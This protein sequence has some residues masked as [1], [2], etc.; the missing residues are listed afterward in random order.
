MWQRIPISKIQILIDYV[1][2]LLKDIDTEKLLTNV[3]LEFITEVSKKTGE[4]STKT[5]AKYHFCEITIYDSGLVFFTGSIHKLW[6]SLNK[7]VAPN[8]KENKLYKGYNGNLFG[9]NDIV[10]IRYHLEQLFDCTPDKMIFQNI[11]LGINTTPLFNPQLFITG[12]LYQNSSLFE[13][14]YNQY[15][16]QSVHQRYIFKI[17]NKSNQY[18][19]LEN[20]LRVELKVLRIKDIKET[21][22]KTFNDVNCETLSKAKKLL[23]KRFEEVVYYD[24]TITKKGLSKTN[25]INLLKYKTPQ[26]WFKLS[27]KQNRLYHKRK[28]LQFISKNSDNLKQQIVKNINQKFEIITQISTTKKNKNTLPFN[29]LSENQNTLPFTTSN[30]GLKSTNKP[31]LKCRVTGIDISMQKEGSILLSHTGLKFYYQTDKNKFDLIKNKYLSKK[32][33]NSSFENQ[34]KELAHNIRNKHSN[35]LRSKEMQ[36]TNQ[37]S[38]IS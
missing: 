25:K 20:T 7:V 29:R 5:V 34:I 21:N 10:D 6:N 18:G 31:P 1:K 9:L 3:N 15:F 35:Y 32:W 4:L 19:I 36:N 13:F 14:K 16:A 28:L 33:I 38:L 27:S 12:L 8:F 17:Y 24:Y 37:L 26:Y 30:I 11:E 23:L 2:I 22:I